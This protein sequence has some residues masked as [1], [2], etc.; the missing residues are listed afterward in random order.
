M[1]LKRFNEKIE[2]SW[3]KEKMIKHFKN[4]EEIEKNDNEINSLVEKYLSYNTHLLPANLQ[5]YLNALQDDT[6]YEYDIED[7][8]VID[9]Y[10][11]PNM[12]YA[13]VS[14]ND[15]EEDDHTKNIPEDFFHFLENPE[16]YKNTKNII[17]ENKKI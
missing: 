16:E 6:H 4:K 13:H 8:R 14:W 7:Y 3:N 1:K 2:S 12:F 9:L 10:Y 11:Y 15:D 5:D 17:Y